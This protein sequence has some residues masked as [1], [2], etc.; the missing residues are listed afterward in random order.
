MEASREVKGMAEYT[1]F[2]KIILYAILGCSV[3]GIVGRKFQVEE[4]DTKLSGI[5]QRLN[6]CN[7]QT[8]LRKPMLPEISNWFPPDQ[9]QQRNVLG[10]DEPEVFYE[11]NGQRYFLSIDG[12]PVSEY[13]RGK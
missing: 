10:G 6:R 5:E 8:D 3:S 11:L 13:V 7:G 2:D 12:K 1:S 4:L 9:I